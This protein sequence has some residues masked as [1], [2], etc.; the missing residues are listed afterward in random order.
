[1]AS[2]PN[3]PQY[4]GTIESTWGQSVADHVIRRY[5]TTAARDADL[6]GAGLTPTDL[7]GQVVAIT[8]AG[9]PTFLEMYRGGIWVGV[10]SGWDVQ[11][12]STHAGADANAN[13]KVT[14]PRAF[15]GFPVVTWSDA[16][17]SDAANN[18][19]IMGGAVVQIA[20]TFFTVRVQGVDAQ[21]IINQGVQIAWHAFYA[22]TP[23][24]LNADG[25]QLLDVN[26]KPYDPEAPTLLA[27]EPIAD[28]DRFTI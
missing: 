8:G 20:A 13:A 26:G 19:A 18:K 11:I 15:G 10:T 14:F 6:A 1:M 22:G 5:A 9:R 27:G 12:G 23:T 16:S 21:P 28:P 3:R 4:Q 24:I 25:G 7:E 2:N 17:N